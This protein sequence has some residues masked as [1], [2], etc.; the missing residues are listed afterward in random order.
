MIGRES[1]VPKR[2][3]RLRFFW[4]PERLVRLGDLERWVPLDSRESGSSGFK[5]EWRKLVT[6]KR[7]RETGMR[8]ENEFL[9]LF[10]FSI[11]RL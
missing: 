9:F 5:R 11:S 2:W 7:E 10:S 3:V 4:V 6:G 1:W 8:E